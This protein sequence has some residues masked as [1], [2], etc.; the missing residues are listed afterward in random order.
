[1]N[2]FGRSNYHWLTSREEKL[3]IH[4]TVFRSTAFQVYSSSEQKLFDLMPNLVK[5]RKFIYQCII[6]GLVSMSGCLEWVFF[7]STAIHRYPGKMI[8]VGSKQ[9]RRLFRSNKGERLRMKRAIHPKSHWDSLHNSWVVGLRVW[10]GQSVYTTHFLHA[11]S[12][13]NILPYSRSFCT[14]EGVMASTSRL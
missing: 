4:E 1:M 2:T 3:F 5:F 14:G 13:N 11:S 10:I 12:T 7:K 8:V 9:S 6:I